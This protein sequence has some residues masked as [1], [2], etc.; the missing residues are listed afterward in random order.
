MIQNLDLLSRLK[1]HYKELYSSQNV[2]EFWQELEKK[3]FFYHKSRPHHL[4]KMDLNTNWFQSENMIGMT[5]YVD[6]FSK[7]LVEF[8][9]KVT[10]FK[11]LGI[12]Y[13]HLMPLLK[14]RP[15]NN[16]GGYAVAD[17]KDIEPKLG[18]MSDFEAVIKTYQ[19]AGIAIAIDF[20]INHTAKEHRWAQAALK[21]D[22]HYQ[23][24][25]MMY[26]DEKI[27]NEF[28]RTVPEVLP[29]IYPGNFT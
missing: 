23:Q 29:D 7:N 15:G 1:N 11:N 25:F 17:Y 21:G 19:D 28:N 13:I 5:L 24:Y 14:S 27:P 4:K 2:H 10:Y 12:T 26:D 22:V 16:D 3:L 9:N 8:T 6:L 18:T 20:V